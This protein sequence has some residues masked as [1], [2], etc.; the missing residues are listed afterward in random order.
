MKEQL[1]TQ[2]INELN[3]LLNVKGDRGGFYY[4]YYELTG[5]EQA[6]VQAQITTYS[7]HWGGLAING[8][9]VAKFNNPE[10]Y[11]ISLDQFSQD[12]AVALFKAVEQEVE[13]GK[14]GILTVDQI[15]ALDRGVWVEKNL[16][17]WFPGNIYFADDLAGSGFKVV[18]DY[19]KIR[20][21]GFLLDF[22]VSGEDFSL[23]NLTTE[24]IKNLQAYSESTQ[25]FAEKSNIV[26]SS[27]LTSQ[28][29][30]GFAANTVLGKIGLSENLSDKIGNRPS[31]FLDMNAV[32]AGLKTVEDEN[33]NKQLFYDGADYQYIDDNRI[34]RIID[35]STGKLALIIDRNAGFP[36]SSND[37]ILDDNQLLSE[38]EQD[39]RVTRKAY[40]GADIDTTFPNAPTI[41]N[42]WQQ[43]S[44]LPTY[45]FSDDKLVIT[46]D[47]DV[48]VVGDADGNNLYGLD[49]E[50][51]ENGEVTKWTDNDQPDTLIGGEGADKFYLGKGDVIIDSGEGDQVNW[52]FPES[53]EPV[54]IDGANN[55]PDDQPRYYTATQRDSNGATTESY[56][57]Q[58]GSLN[59]FAEKA[60]GEKLEFVGSL[61][62]FI[63]TSTSPNS[64]NFEYLPNTWNVGYYAVQHDRAKDI[65]YYRF[66]EGTVIEHAN[67]TENPERIYLVNEDNTPI[68]DGDFGINYEYIN[69]DPE[70]GV[71]RLE[72]DA[73]KDFYI[74]NDSEWENFSGRA[75]PAWIETYLTPIQEE[76]STISEQTGNDGQ[77]TG[78]DPTTSAN[79][80]VP[81]QT[82]VSN[83]STP[84]L[85]ENDIVSSI[86]NNDTQGSDAENNVIPTEAGNDSLTGDTGDNFVDTAN[87]NDTLLGGT[88]VQALNSVEEVAITDENA[89]TIFVSDPSLGVSSNPEELDPNSDDEIVNSFTP[90][91]DTI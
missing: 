79:G 21:I 27:Y 74:G 26:F 42:V 20:P 69:Y 39:F 53:E 33:G 85:N 30:I 86:E 40:V 71:R 67:G 84:I 59:P 82:T 19:L 18:S 83:E 65:T 88:D 4:R 16:G 44:E 73:S 43:T 11:N 76:L 7:G 48:V 78:Q 35:K 51:D 36:A 56:Q 31:D 24:Y 2:D 52:L 61:D 28:E 8:N 12:I 9:T 62:N 25:D 13:D 32:K 29:G 10:I 14:T 87:E 37:E 55:S 22:I 60:P 41:P 38:E 5:S 64:S 75:T 3:E 90:T 80:T 70:N 63:L 91:E 17:E 47:D 77:T 49:V 72:D 57:L 58:L 66:E 1:T 50:F 45:S 81:D 15:Q 46:Q 89:E 23:K 68:K 6:L 54:L 34:V